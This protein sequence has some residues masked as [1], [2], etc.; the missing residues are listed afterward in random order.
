VGE[1]EVETPARDRTPV[2]VATIDGQTDR[3]QL[4]LAP[5]PLQF[6]HGSAGSEDG[7]HVDA[8]HAMGLHQ[9]DGVEPEGPQAALHRPARR[10]CRVVPGPLRM[11]TCLGAKMGPRG[12]AA[13]RGQRAP[14][15]PFERAV[16]R[17]IVDVVDAQLEGMVNRPDR[18]L[19][20]HR[21]VPVIQAGTTGREH[22]DVDA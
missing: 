9:V 4:A 21:P 3:A 10:G 1:D 16:R 12:E 22:R 2:K 8:V 13:E 6:V 5:Q 7:V 18:V 14:Q 17:R 11:H 15:T 20:G 19:V